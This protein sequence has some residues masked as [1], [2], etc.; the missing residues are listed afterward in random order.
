MIRV[1]LIFI[2]LLVSVWIGVQLNRDPGYLLIAINHWTIETSLWVAILGLIL[3]FFILHAVL[4]ILSKISK[5]PATF[6]RWQAKRRVQKAQAKTQRGL[7]E[8]SEGH[9]AQA[10]NHLIKALPDTDSPLLNYLTAARAA[11][12][13]GDNKLRDDYL[14]EAQ[15]SMPDAKIAVELTQAQLQLAN[16]QWEQ[17]LATLRHLQDLAPNHPYVLKLLMRLYK[18]VKDWPQL[19]ALLPA[20]K[21]N[22]VLSEKGFDLLRHQAYLEAMTELT[23]PEALNKMVASLPKDLRDNAELMA[24]YCNFLL[25]R[26]EDVKAEPILRHCLRKQFDEKL[27]TLYGQLNLGDK[28]LIFAE[29][30]V[31]KNPDSAALYLCLGRLSLRNN[32]WG[33]ARHYFEKSLSI[34]PEA[35]SYLELG[36]LLERLNDQAGACEAYRQGLTLTINQVSV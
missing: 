27:I 33:K 20:L 29:S 17:A 31:K 19:I 10:K 7:I 11:Q 2:V 21:K 9:W 6:R 13:M 8:F 14:R 18:E 36:K 28:P 32:L 16:K 15:Q 30:L 3:V 1:L 5:S 22:H 24:I 12:E 34:T 23:E 4:L 26:H 35:A 25:E